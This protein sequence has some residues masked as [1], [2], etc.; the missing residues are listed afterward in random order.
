MP[1]MPCDRD[2]VLKALREAAKLLSDY[3][4]ATHRDPA[5]TINR[6]INLLDNQELAEAIMRMDQVQS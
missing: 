3:V 2:V 1:L 5:A 6:L 4:E